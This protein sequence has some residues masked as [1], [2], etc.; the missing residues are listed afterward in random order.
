MSKCCIIIPCFNEQSRILGDDFLA[1]LN[2]NNNFSFVFVDDGSTDD[3]YLALKKLSNKHDR[4]SCYRLQQNCGK[5]EAVR[6]GMNQVINEEFNYYGFIDAD[7]AIPLDEMGKL[8][9]EL[10][11]TKNIEFVYSSKNSNLNKELEMKFKRFFVG[12]VLSILVKWSLK[13][14]VYDTQCGCKLMTKKIAEISFKDKFLSPWLFDIEIFW[15]LINVF[16][17]AYILEKT[18]EIPLDNLYN[19]G[20]SKVRIADL[21]KLPVEFLKIHNYYKK[22]TSVN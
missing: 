10:I 15:R 22:R 11:S 4:I 13:I 1:F 18:K 20:S 14:D 3:T 9:N 8:Y 21:I 6:Y 16:G 12:R 2:T 19:R 5:A 17:R 7:L